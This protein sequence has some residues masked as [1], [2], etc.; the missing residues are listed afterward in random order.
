MNAGRKLIVDPFLSNWLPQQ[1]PEEL[2]QLEK[3]LLRDGCLDPLKVWKGE[4]VIVDGQT[5]FKF[6]TKHKIPYKIEELEFE[7]R[8][9]VLEW[10]IEFQYGRRNGNPEQLSIG[11]GRLIEERKKE[12]KA[13]AKANISGD[14]DEAQAMEDDED[15]SPV[16]AKAQQD[17]VV[18][19]AAEQGITPAKAVEVSQYTK[20][21]N[22]IEAAGAMNLRNR[23]VSKGIKSDKASLSMVAELSPADIKKVE[24]EST[25]CAT[26]SQALTRCGFA[27]ES[28]KDKVK[29]PGKKPNLGA[30]FGVIEQSL[31]NAIKA[32]ESC[33]GACGGPNNLSKPVKSAVL[34][35]GTKLG[36]WKQAYRNS[37]K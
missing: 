19:V 2:L 32:I 30:A 23:I 22:A 17:A 24:L 7:K 4:D 14:D 13:A 11:Q 16:V 21:I 15:E 18:K 6:C 31:K 25:T 28:K 27:K 33:E 36:Q 1:S 8:S 34:D 12:A 26:L 5:R 9:D 20:N 35:A 3:N 29:T 37:K 10:M